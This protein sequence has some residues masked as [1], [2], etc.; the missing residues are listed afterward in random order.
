MRRK[1]PEKPEVVMARRVP[2]SSS[3][4]PQALD[5]S[6]RPL[7]YWPEDSVR[8]AIL[9]NIQG[10]VRR[11]ILQE[12]LDSGDSDF[13]P[14]GLL[15]P[16]LEPEL[17]SLLGKI[18][19]MIL[20]GEYLPNY[21]PEEVEIARIALKSVTADVI[22]IRAFME[23]DNLTHYRVVDE[24]E[25]EFRQ[26]INE[27][28]IPLSTEELLHLIDT[29]DG[30]GEPGLVLPFLAMNAEYDDPENLRGFIS[31]RSDFYPGVGR[32]YSQRTNAFLDSLL[33]KVEPEDEGDE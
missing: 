6:F 14:E 4:S 2:L 28:P 19:P 13:P 18:H 22:S 1:Q 29:S 7:T 32:H 24:Y 5:L 21:L 12:A 16:I 8:L 33:P 25:T 23:A 3:S 11:R 30:H 17:R 15:Q 10:E 26:P 20:G 9:G 27:S 31:V